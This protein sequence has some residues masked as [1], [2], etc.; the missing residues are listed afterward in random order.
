MKCKFGLLSLSL[1]LFGCNDQQ[2]TNQ[3]TLVPEKPKNIIMVVGDGMG[4]A[5]IS[6]YRYFHDDPNT[7]GME[8]TVFD[9]TL[10]GMSSTYPASV[11]GYVTDSAAG[12]T[13]LSAGVKT[14]N[15]AIAMD[16]NKQPVTTVLEV[17]KRLGKKTGVVV[18]SQVNHATP[19]GFMSHNVARGN[20][21]EIAD[22]YVENYQMYDVVLGGGWKFFLREDR[23]LVSEFKE[24]GYQYIDDYADLETVQQDKPLF[25]LF[26]DVGLPWAL[27]DSDPNRL[28]TMTSTALNQLESDKGFFMLVEASQVDWGGH[29]NDIAAAMGE[30]QDLASTLEM[31]EDYVAQ[32]PDTLVVVT[33]DH[34][35]GGMT[36]G[37]N[38]KYQ[39]NPEILRT[40]KHSPSYIAEQLLHTDITP[41]LAAELLNFK[42]TKSELALLN[43]SKNIAE[44]NPSSTSEG[45]PYADASAD[46]VKKSL[47]VNIKHI[48]DARTLTG[49]TS[50]AHTAVDVPVFAFGSHS[51]SFVGLS[52]NTD[53]AKTVFSLL[54]QK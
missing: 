18:T 9:R 20:Y 46:A 3:T 15:G 40:M 26:A 11:S 49:W 8:Q 50:G 39:W 33:A 53:I 54:E 5:Y 51:E 25:G 41:E 27:D 28:K 47:Y 34:S 38:G 4:P 37:A 24:L 6:A 22:S 30:M 16:V 14:Y 29:S 48:I 7:A 17:S 12:A 35:T 43:S 42:L 2:Q 32:H 36:L 23:D 10:V 44:D 21:D 1:V 13:A 45:N 19:A 31:L 52:N